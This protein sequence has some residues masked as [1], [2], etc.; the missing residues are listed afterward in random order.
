MGIAAQP[1][2]PIDVLLVDESLPLAQRLAKATGAPVVMMLTAPSQREHAQR[3]RELGFPAYVV[4]PLGPEALRDGVLAALG[5]R[6]APH[7]APASVRAPH[8]LLRELSVLVAE[9]SPVNLKLL[10]RILEKAGHRVTGVGDG[11]AALAAIEGKRFDIVFMD[12]QMPVLDGLK[13]VRSVRDREKKQ[14]LPRLPVVAVTAHAMKGDREQCLAAGFHGYVTKPIRI[15]DL[16]TELDRL[17]GDASA[18]TAS[19]AA[20]PIA[21]R[22]AASAISSSEVDVFDEEAALA[23]ADNDRDLARELG[24]MLLEEAPRLLRELEAARARGDA[25]TFGR[26]AHTLKGQADHYGS[27]R[28]RDLARALELAGKAG[29]PLP[30]ALRADVASLEAAFEQ[31][32]DRVSTFVKDESDS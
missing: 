13:T 3:C 26:T 9:D 32:L 12:I 15:R 1:S 19:I 14:G 8:H 21:P 18:T 28:A 7:P 27:V 5:L 31:L 6:T 17:L 2:S 29:P 25:A 10:S 16:F 11:R 22:E 20:A 24:A 23:R 4:K 30:E